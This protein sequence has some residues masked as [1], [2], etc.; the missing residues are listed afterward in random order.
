[1]RQIHNSTACVQLAGLF[2]RFASRVGGSKIE[3]VTVTAELSAGMGYVA[4]PMPTIRRIV[5]RRFHM[6]LIESLAHDFI[7]RSV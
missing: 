3:V 5:D 1:M 6:E 4:S 7:L 2:C